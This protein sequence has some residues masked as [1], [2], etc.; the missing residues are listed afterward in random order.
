MA[1]LKF[2]QLA[3]TEKLRMRELYDLVVNRE[4]RDIGSVSIE[5]FADQVLK[6]FA[7]STAPNFEQYME[8]CKKDN[9]F[10]EQAFEN[11]AIVQEGYAEHFVSEELINQA[12]KRSKG[13]QRIKVT[14]KRASQ[15]EKAQ[16]AKRKRDLRAKETEDQ[17]QQRRI[18]DAQSKRGTRA[19]ETQE[20]G[21]QRRSKNAENMN[22]TRA[23]ET[24]VQSEQRRSAI[25][26]INRTTRANALPKLENI[27]RRAI[28]SENDIESFADKIGDMTEVC[29]FVHCKAL[30]FKGEHVKGSKPNEYNKCCN[31]GKMKI[32]LPFS[33]YPPE[34][35]KLMVRK[36]RGIAKH[37]HENIRSYNSSFAFGSMRAE[38]QDRSTMPYCYRI[39]GQVYHTVN[40]AAHPDENEIPSHA[41]LFFYDSAEAIDIRL[42]H[43][44]NERCTRNVMQVIDQ[45]LSRVSPYY[46]AFRTMKEVE[47]EE[48]AKAENEGRLPAKLKLVFDLNAHVDKRRYNIPRSN[49]VAAV[50]ALRDGEEVPEAE[51]IAVHQHGQKLKRLTKFDKRTESMIYPLFFPSGKGGPVANMTDDNGRKVTFN[52]YYRYLTAVRP[53]K[54]LEKRDTGDRASES[55]GE[56]FEKYDWGDDPEM[57]DF[58]PLRTGGKLYHQYLV[59]GYVKTEQD[60]LDYIRLHQKELK[61]E[62]YK[63]L[64]DYLQ[65]TADKLGKGVGK[66]VILPSSFKGS[67]RHCAQA[68]QDSMAM[69]RRYGKP[70]LFLTFTC[71]PN[72]SAIKRNLLPGNTALD[73]PDLVC[74]V[75]NLYLKDLKEQITQERIFGK[76]LASTYV[77]EFQ[78]RGLPHAHILLILDSESQ[79]RDSEQIDN[80]VWARF[81]DKEKYPRLF[82]TITRD[83]IHGP[84]GMLNPKSVCMEENKK[85]GKLKCSKTYP[86]EFREQT[87][88]GE[89]SYALYKRPN[90]G[91]HI[92]KSGNIIDN[93]WVVPYNPYLSLRYDAHI[94]VEICASVK[95]VKYLYK[96]CY[97]G[98]DCAR[99]V[100]EKE[101]T[102][103]H[104]ETKQYVDMR[105]VTPHEAFWRMFELDLDGRSHAITRLDLHLPDNQIVA[106]QPGEN[107]KAKLNDA[108]LRNTTLTAWFELNKRDKRAKDLYYYEIPEHYTY[109][110]EGNRQWTR[111]GGELGNKKTWKPCIGR[112]YSVGVSQGDIFYLRLLLLHVKG[113]EK[114]EDLLAFEGVTYQTFKEAAIARELLD[115]GEEWIKH[116]EE[117]A[118]F[119][120]PMLLRQ[121]FVSILTHGENVINAN[122]IWEMFKDDM[123]EDFLHRGND[124][125][126]SENLAKRDIEEQLVINGKTLTDY[127]IELAEHLE[128][129][130]DNGW[131]IEEELE[132]GKVMRQSMN[133]RQ[134]AIVTR[135]FDML[136]KMNQGNLKNGSLFID[137]PGGSGKTY[138]YRTL[139]HLFRAHGIKYNTSS[140]MGIAA[141]LLPDGRT[142]HKTF[143]FPFNM[144][145]DASSNAKAN[146]KTGR[147][148][149]DTRVIIVDEISMVPKYALEMIDKKLK[150][151]M[152]NDLPFGGKIVIIGGDF[153]QILPVKRKAGKSELLSLSV[154]NSKLWKLFSSNIYRLKENKRVVHEHT[155]EENESGNFEEFILK[156]GNGEL[157]ADDDEY[158]D[159]PDHCVAKSDLIDETFGEMIATKSYAEMATR[160]ILTTTNEKALEINDKVLNRLKE[161]EAQVYN[162]IDEVD[163]NEPK[164]FIEYPTEFLYTLNDAGL[165]PHEL[166]L[167]KNC[168]VILLRNLNPAAGLCNGTRLLVKEMHKYILECEI[169]TGDKAGERVY[170]PKIKLTSPKGTFP[171]ELS[172]KQ[173]PVKLCYAMTINKSQGQT[174][175]FVGLDLVDAVFSHGQTYVAFSRV[176]GWKSLKVAVN[177]EKGNKI[178]NVVWKEVLLDKV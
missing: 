138:T 105:Y 10:M 135:V 132:L 164:G 71:N 175:D 106:Y 172:R 17:A 37:F 72:W 7:I 28:E 102:I 174:L 46:H 39:Q 25:A 54:A 12:T 36:D 147:E 9:D 89:D 41:H 131:N 57:Y 4:N 3:T 151:L 45:A 119:Q 137:G 100:I 15:V 79:I 92:E 160:V 30:Y 68:Y 29:K 20:Q 178:K 31:F 154:K 63:V 62:S 14:R 60:R 111:K 159:I 88:V 8:K 69:V 146:N 165:P 34:L 22:S 173:F 75:F 32:E 85:N 24:Q 133:N 94:N 98:H 170:I 58:N 101:N 139:C 152:D 96:Y 48:I 145:K 121:L 113:A 110:K 73:E 90:D 44:A 86:K 161:V 141:N 33:D 61:V 6:L 66:N 47:D 99:M 136:E 156:M 157:E 125:L 167:A 158:I 84:C 177:P 117:A 19:N 120:S 87:E 65:E 38:T 35:Y 169:M 168:P 128:D 108:E 51:G 107:L 91:M 144:D 59:D 114:W 56:P 93:R 78:K 116:F 67:P 124:A 27:A 1:K 21:E 70:S 97:K 109:A 2:D 115:S 11:V 5:K 53:C 80:I 118:S 16:E 42:E 112:L 134:Q 23:N 64:K 153:R 55:F 83:M 166:K 143:G 163:T 52:Q 150:E 49:E 18:A 77:V 76:V 82:K 13:K 43:P 130:E 74:R 148:L 104:D 123:C 140:W 26:Q 171:F 40:L 149:T 129:N 95:S 122:E 142:M 155:D 50:F 126:R 162:S 81:P 127:G 103:E 176:R